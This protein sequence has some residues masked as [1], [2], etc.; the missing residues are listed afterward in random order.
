MSSSYRSSKKS[1]NIATIIDQFR[2]AST[3]L[4]PYEILFGTNPPVLHLPTLSKTAI[5]DPAAYNVSLQNKS[6]ELREMVDA[7]IIKSS[8]D[9]KCSYNY[10]THETFSVGQQVLL[11]DPTAQ[12]LD[13][14]WTGQWTVTSLRV[15]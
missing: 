8:H 6:L 14:H 5:L 12:K 10:C 7:D 1:P 9:Q 4:S 15:L 13:P 11:K 3:G 2:H